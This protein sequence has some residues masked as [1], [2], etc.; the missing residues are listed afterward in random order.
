MF[1]FSYKNGNSGEITGYAK[2]MLVAKLCGY[3]LKTELEP[4]S[5]D[6]KWYLPNDTVYLELLAEYEKNKKIDELVS[7]YATDKK[8]L[9]EYYIEATVYGE[10][11]QE[12]NEELTALD[13]KFDEEIASLN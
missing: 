11:T 10:D 1:Y 7:Q 9:M 8:T 13:K 2:N 12:L 4:V 6:N 5:L 3:N